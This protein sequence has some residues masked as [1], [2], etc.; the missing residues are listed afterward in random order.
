MT[1]LILFASFVIHCLLQAVIWLI[2]AN[3]IL[4]WLIAFDVINMRNRTANQIVRFIDAATRPILR[5]LRRIIPPLG[6]LDLSPMIVIILLA[7]TDD[8][9]RPALT[10]WLIS[11]TDGGVVG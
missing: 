4:S 2:I 5:P 9:L 1:A 10:A 3:V 7:G 6:G 11:L 8:I